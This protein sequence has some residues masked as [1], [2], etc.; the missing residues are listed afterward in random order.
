MNKPHLL[1]CIVLSAITISCTPFLKEN[2]TKAADEAIQKNPELQELDNL[3]KQIAALKDFK[4][5]SKGI[6][7]HGLPALYYSY[8][9][10]NDFDE[11][12]KFFRDYLMKNG[13]ESV[14]NPSNNRTS[15]FKKHSIRII[16]Q[17]GGMGTDSNYGITCEKSQ[18]AG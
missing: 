12:D 2:R 14:S 13:W 6:S 10:E 1:L 5:I 7:S 15:A 16:I 4:F 18:V 11:T 8:Y 3:C 17:Y 9:S